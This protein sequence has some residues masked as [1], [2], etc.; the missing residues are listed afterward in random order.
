MN[1]IDL[2][3]D[4]GES[5]GVWRKGN[6]DEILQIVTSA[7]VACGFHAGDPRTM[8]ETIRRCKNRGV[9]IG[10]HPGFK[11]LEGF[12]RFE[13]YGIEID[14]LKSLVLYQIGA[15]Q[16]L[17]RREAAE[18]GHFKLHGALSNMASRDRGL[19]EGV[20]SAIVEADL[21]LPVFATASTE[22]QRAAEAVGVECV[23]EVFADRAYEDDG[24]LVPRSDAAAMI[25]DP[26]ICAENVLRI[27]E[28]GVVVSRNGVKV[29]VDARTV[30]VHGDTDEAVAIAA[31]V[32]A[33]LEN[34]GIAVSRPDRC[35][36][37]QASF[38]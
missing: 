24:T 33:R 30:C 10:A 36:G 7:N 9:G 28:S 29:P 18:V 1:S 20:L 16:C 5:F 3:S 27:A 25:L 31:A 15:L 32:R 12:G 21:R 34:A 35:L 11:D 23:A 4:I 8:R 22:L 13:I 6:D 17:A 38:S 14:D 26:R 37:G 2:N 19:A